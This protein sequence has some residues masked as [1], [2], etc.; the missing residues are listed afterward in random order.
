MAP[1]F[2]RTCRV[3]CKWASESQP[4]T[5]SPAKSMMGMSLLQHPSTTGKLCAQPASV[6]LLHKSTMAAG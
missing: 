1:T 5:L 3:S 6:L 4:A 2:L